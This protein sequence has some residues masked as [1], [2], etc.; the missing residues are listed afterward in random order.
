VEHL[1]VVIADT[2]D[3]FTELVREIR[4]VRLQMEVDFLRENLALNLVEI[5]TDHANHISDLI[6]VALIP[7]ELT[8]K[9]DQSNQDRRG[10][11]IAQHES[12]RFQIVLNQKLK[13]HF[14][15]PIVFLV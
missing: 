14:K 13:I 10:F 5:R 9:V 6:N 7:R 2:S 15:Q 4:E 1:L 3:H 8:Q 12:L 11:P